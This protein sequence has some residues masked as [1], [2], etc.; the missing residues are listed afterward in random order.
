M[1]LKAE[2]E[3]RSKV[4]SKKKKQKTDRP[5]YERLVRRPTGRPA[6]LFEKKLLSPKLYVR[7]ECA[8]DENRP[9]ILLS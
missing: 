9:Q 4:P 5:E 1:L 2:H 3:S 8:C 6:D 7:F